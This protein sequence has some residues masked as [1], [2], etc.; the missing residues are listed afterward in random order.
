M[1]KHVVWRNKLIN[2]CQNTLYEGKNLLMYI[3]THCMKEQTYWCMSKHIVWRNKL[4]NV[5][6]NTLYEG[7]NLLMY[8]KTHC[9]KEKTY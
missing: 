1:S 3:K 9:M 8:I 5:C 4:I 6:Q 7:T 2:V